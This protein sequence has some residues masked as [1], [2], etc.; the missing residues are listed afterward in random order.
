MA[1][2]TYGGIFNWTTPP[3]ASIV[4]TNKK[5]IANFHSAMMYAHYE[6][7]CLQLK[8][9]TITYLKKID[10]KHPFLVKVEK[11]DENR[12]TTIGKY[13]YILNHGGNIPDDIMA[14]IMPH[15]ERIVQE[16]FG[17]SALSPAVAVDPAP[18]LVISIQDR[19]KEKSHDVAGEIE[20]WIDDFYF[21]RKTPTKTVDDFVNLFKGY[22]LKSPHA[23]IISEIFD[24]RS[25]EITLAIEGVDKDLAEGYSNYTKA[26]LKKYDQFYKNL[27]KA[28]NMMQEVA[29]VERTP[30]KKKPVSQEKLVAR[31]KYKKEDSSVGIVSLSPVQIPGS[32]EVW[33]YN[34]KTRKLSHYKALDESGITV[35]GASLINYSSDSV[36]KTLRKPAEALAAFKKSTKVKLRTFLADLSTIDVACNG[37]VNEHHIILR[38]DK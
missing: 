1:S 27:F 33:L 9:E 29:K 3:F 14:T 36:E 23:R 22:D 11:M 2:K 28:C 37:K 17:N 5:F 16:E 26:D 7:S 35:K 32:K 25:K 38:I 31:L 30:R 4:K 20:G 8:K 6:L 21:D 24:K 18:K 15:L 12:F 10:P 13:L 19:L 34:V